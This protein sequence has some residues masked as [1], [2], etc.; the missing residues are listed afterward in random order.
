MG[1]FEAQSQSRADRQDQGT[2]DRSRGC[3]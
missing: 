3:V 1:S 2:G